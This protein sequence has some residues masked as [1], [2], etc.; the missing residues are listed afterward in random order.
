MKIRR[1]HKRVVSFNRK[2]FKELRTKEHLSQ[3]KLSIE[4][5]VD[6]ATI[7]RVES[8]EIDCPNIEFIYRMSKY[9]EEPIENFL[10]INNKVF[11]EI[12]GA[13]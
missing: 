1:K 12:I 2:W 11:N 7:I 6:K 9:F 5:E 10:K 3:N 8:G 13:Y 4:T